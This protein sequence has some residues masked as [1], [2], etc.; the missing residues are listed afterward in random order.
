M[1]GDKIVQLLHRH[2]H[3]LASGWPLPCFGRT[4]V[5]AVPPALASADG[6]GP[7]AL[8]AVNEASEKRRPA[9][10]LR[11]RHLGAARLQPATPQLHN[12]PF[13]FEKGF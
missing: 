7:A 10:D 8:G 5:I 4:G 3:A 11:G 13:L 2:G 1:A 9:N 6:N 12:P